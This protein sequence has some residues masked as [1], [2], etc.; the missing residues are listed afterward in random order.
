MRKYVL[1]TFLGIFIIISNSNISRAISAT[2]KLAS[3][4]E[5][6]NQAPGQKTETQEELE[7]EIYGEPEPLKQKTWYKSNTAAINLYLDNFA[8][9][10]IGISYYHTNK[11]FWQAQFNQVIP[12][13]LRMAYTYGIG[14]YFFFDINIFK[15]NQEFRFIPGFGIGAK[16]EGLV[17]P[18]PTIGGIPLQIRSRKFRTDIYLGVMLAPRDEIRNITGNNDININIGYG[19][20]FGQQ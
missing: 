2:T 3:D 18:I 9:P 17:L 19:I 1:F 16:N 7:K 12:N 10:N 15:K 8:Y 4:T 14:S 11:I 5:K 6:T 20:E 13:K